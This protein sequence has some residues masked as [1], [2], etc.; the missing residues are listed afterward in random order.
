MEPLGL[1]ARES[2]V[3]MWITHGKTDAEIATIIGVSTSTVGKHLEW[4]Y[5][6]LGVENRMAAA[7]RALAFISSR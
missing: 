4:I 5:Q 3:L 6:K 7:M 2:E 1:T